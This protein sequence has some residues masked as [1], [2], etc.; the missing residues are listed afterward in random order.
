[1]PLLSLPK[2][3]LPGR[4]VLDRSKF[5]GWRG[6]ILT[7]PDSELFVEIELESEIHHRHSLLSKAQTHR[8][9]FQSWACC[10]VGT[11]FRWRS[12][13]LAILDR[14]VLAVVDRRHCWYVEQVVYGELSWYFDD[15]GVGLDDVALTE[16]AEVGLVV[17]E[18]VLE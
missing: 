16:V 1:M 11:P 15:I 12:R 6:L 13:A 18:I 3:T 8:L 4:T 17:A 9:Q 7:L 10:Q 5:H 14:T 2:C